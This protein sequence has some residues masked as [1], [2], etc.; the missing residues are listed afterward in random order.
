[1][2]LKSTVSQSFLLFLCL[3]VAFLTACNLTEEEK[4]VYLFSYFVGNGE[5]GLHL[6]WSEDG[7]TW[8]ALN[9]GKSLLQPLV[10]ESQLMRDP[11]ITQTPDSTFH[12]V[13]TTSWDGQT[14]GYANSKDLINWSEQKAIPVMAHEDSVV[15]CWAPEINYIPEDNQFIIYWS[16]TIT[17]Q[18]PE[19][20]DS[21]EKGKQRNHRIYYT[22]TSDFENFLPTQLLY[23]P[24]YTVID[25]SIYPLEDGRYAMFIK[26]ETELPEAEKN[27]RLA[28]AE[29][30]I[31][32][33]SV[34]GPPI[35]GDY[36]A[37][38]PTALQ[39]DGQWH[40]YFDK[41]RKDEFGLLVSDDLENWEEQSEQLNMPE[42][43]RHG[44]AFS[45]PASF[46]EELKSSLA[47]Q[48]IV[49][50]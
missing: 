34:A 27:I 39:I 2:N 19:T 43:M 49:E 28:Y 33:Y 48:Q 23:E 50:K 35:T 24:G 17:D 6:A 37:E 29:E 45:V 9:D 41:Y 8:Q 47:G 46:L 11:C 31:G 20:A 21:H 36:W 22:L 5:D 13:W 1:M 26:N 30:I 32:P 38:G 16:S 12:M 44:T 42:S 18:F 15:N 3:F 7:K 4:E 10:G 40:L 14:I 25:G